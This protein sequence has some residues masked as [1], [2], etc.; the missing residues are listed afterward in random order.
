MQIDTGASVSV[1]SSTLWESLGRPTLQ[2][3]TRRLE[4]YDGHALKALGKLCTTVEMNGRLNPA[5]LMR[6]MEA[7]LSDL[8]GLLIYQDDILV[9]ADNHDSLQKRLM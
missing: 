5:E 8:K 3:C 6:T 2:K 9:F 1:L 7:I 4:A